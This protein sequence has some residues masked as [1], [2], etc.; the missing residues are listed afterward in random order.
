ME[1]L[2][3]DLEN[4]DLEDIMN[5]FKLNY[6]FNETDLK[7]AHR[8]ALRTHPDKSRLPDKFFIFFM[9]AYKI[10]SKIYYFRC[11]KGGGL[12]EYRAETDAGHI[13]LLR[14]LDGKPIGEFNDWFNDMF[15]KT[16][17]VDS[18]T[19]SGYGEWYQKGTV[20]EN[21]KVPLHNFAAAFEDEKE[22]CRALAIQGAVEMLG[23]EGGYSLSREKPR[24][25]T[26]RI[27]S[28]L[29]YDDLKK[30]HTETVVPVT[31]ADFEKKQKFSNLDSMRK[32]RREQNTEPQSLAQ[33]RRYLEQRAEEKDELSAHRL[34][35]I[36]KRDEEM[37]EMNKVWWAHLKRL[38]HE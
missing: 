4:Y 9:K 27:F 29:G 25:Y 31:R 24:E 34:Y 23:D 2:D 1:D 15:E 11:K 14:K 38:T 30:V 20:V 6:N 13:Q 36:L 19:D 26:S 37:G 18:N 5:L 8:I 33:A 32:H 22:K 35:S 28:K 21:R 17:V 12:E 10:I 7:Q 3:L 16:K